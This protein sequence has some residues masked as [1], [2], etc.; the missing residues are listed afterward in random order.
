MK[1]PND[2]Q[3]RGGSLRFIAALVACCIF[4]PL[5]KAQELAPVTVVDHGP[6]APQQLAKHYVVLI[7]FDGFRYDYPRR[8]G[9]QNVL[10]VAAKGAS[11][12]KGM[13]PSYPSITFPNHYTLVTGLYPEHHGIVEN[14]FY[15]PARKQVYSYQDATTVTDG[16]WYGGT[17]LWVLAEQQGMRAACF[18][19]PGSEADIRG[20]RPSNYAK[21][22][23]KFPNEKRVEQVLAWL[24]L[25]PA[26]RPHFITL[27]FSD[28]DSAGHR[29]GPDSPEVA[30]A[31]HEVDAELG[32]LARGI[33]ALKL[34]VDIVVVADHGMAQVPPRWINLDEH[35]LDLSLLEKYEGIF[36]YAKSD[37]DAQKIFEAMR[38]GTAEY[39]VYRR[40][41][42]PK[43]L[44]F[45][46]NSRA[47]DPVIVETGPYA[48]RVHADPAR[49]QPNPGAH[50]FDP[51]ILP[52][53]NAL[54]VAE[55]PDIRAGVTVAPFENVNVYPLIAKILGLDIHA[56]KTGPIDGK[57]SV[58]QPILRTNLAASAKQ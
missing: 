38:P 41:D 46:S 13:I 24:R 57:L 16:S 21:Y 39:K 5:G 32:K 33:Q 1:S 48:I 30:E 8:Y 34:A 40:A 26:Q 53:M 54:F 29:Y 25:P 36:L 52:E 3:C 51:A 11:A 43:H 22:D 58:L 35:G 56:L 18:F 23:T 9:A 4:G 14:T 42:L 15:D 31:V 27:Y 19:W 12:P 47:G 17:P 55:G 45:D 6:N 7:S 50:G 28:T 49:P 20:I 2:L 10:A 44:R 37:A